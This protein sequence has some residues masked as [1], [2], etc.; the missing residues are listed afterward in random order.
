MRLDIA[1]IFKNEIEEINEDD[2]YSDLDDMKLQTQIN[3]YIRKV[4]KS[5][6]KLNVLDENSI[7]KE[8]ISFIN[9]KLNKNIE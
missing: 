4:V 2:E 9:F 3:K 6:K 1:R 7:T 8:I 5:N